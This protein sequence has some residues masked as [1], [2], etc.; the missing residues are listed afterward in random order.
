MK[1]LDK[2]AN[3]ENVLIFLHIPKAAG[4]TLHRII[5]KQYEP[6]TIFTIPSFYSSKEEFRQ[7]AEF[8]LKEIKV[9]KGHMFFGLHEVLPNPSTY[10]TFLRD[11]VERIISHYYYVL[12][13]PIHYLYKDV[14]A[15]NMSL[16]EYAGSGLSL[17][18]DNGQTRFIAGFNFLDHSQ[19]ASQEMLEV[20]K[21]NLKS[22]FAVVGIVEEFN[23]SLI[24][25][26]KRFD[27]KTPFYVKE[28]TTKNRLKKKIISKDTLEVIKKY[29]ELD[30]EL[31]RYAKDI[32]EDLVNQQ[33]ASFEREIKVFNLLNGVYQ[34][35]RGLY[36]SSR[37]A[38]LKMMG[39]C[40]SNEVEQYF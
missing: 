26:R 30:I 40:Q 6:S 22:H 29:N 24:T 33:D 21:Q 8:Q 17:E 18:L 35:Y 1:K 14:K 2:H 3:Q 7:A 11:P 19:P 16:K 13:N 31:Y 39:R 9:L 15:N 4:S 23:K 38:E 28:N 37:L 5:E 25:L 32:F 20:A 12:Q 10:I 34:T 27:W 36:A